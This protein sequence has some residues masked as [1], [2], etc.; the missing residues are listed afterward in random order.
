MSHKEALEAGV[1]YG[2]AIALTWADSKAR[3]S[4]YMELF[5]AVYT[6]R[7]S[8]AKALELLDRPSAPARSEVLEVRLLMQHVLEAMAGARERT[9]KEAAKE[10]GGAK[11]DGNGAEE[12]GGTAA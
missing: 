7:V 12:S 3:L 5:S 1:G 8:C 10:A 6:A 9:A 11:G 2:T 4:A